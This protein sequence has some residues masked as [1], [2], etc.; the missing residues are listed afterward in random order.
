MER[1]EGD[2]FRNRGSG[3]IIR[4]CVR[5][6]LG[7]DRC[8]IADVDRHSPPHRGGLITASSVIGGLSRGR[9]VYSSSRKFPPG[10]LSTASDC[11]GLGGISRGPDGQSGF[12]GRDASAPRR[13]GH[14]GGDPDR[15]RNYVVRT[16]Y[17]AVTLKRTCE[18]PEGRMGNAAVGKSGRQKGDHHDRG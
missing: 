3:R 9:L 17:L 5:L 2:P 12:G 15:G 16:V 11:R 13:C 6:G 10:G 1:Q 18:R 8:C 7:D 4:R 14:D